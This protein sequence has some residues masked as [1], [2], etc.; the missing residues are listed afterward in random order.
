MTIFELQN[1]TQKYYKKTQ[2]NKQRKKNKKQQPPKNT[3]PPKPNNNKKAHTKKTHT[4]NL[5]PLWTGAYNKAKYR[6]TSGGV[7]ANLTFPKEVIKSFCYRS[8]I[9]SCSSWPWKMQR[10]TSSETFGISLTT[11]KT[12]LL[13][14]P[15]FL[16][17]SHGKTKTSL[18]APT[19]RK[20]KTKNP[21]LEAKFFASTARSF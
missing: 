19:L 7:G 5:I 6:I 15:L 12:A 8:D 20:N 2:P 4:T 18:G 11:G 21:N 3:T 10:E 9:Y 16:H 14:H 17:I 1:N 13:H